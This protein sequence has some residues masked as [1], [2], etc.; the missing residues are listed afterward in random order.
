MEIQT[1]IKVETYLP[2]F[3]GFYES[4]FSPTEDME[5]D[6]I[7]EERENKG[8][9]KIEF[10]QFEF[11]YDSYETDVAHCCCSFIE[12]EL[13]QY[14]EGVNFQLINSPKE[15]NFATDSIHVEIELNEEKI[16]N[17]KKFI[18]EHS[19]EFAEYI[20]DRYTSYD[21]F[22]SYYSNNPLDWL[23]SIDD[24][25]KHKHQLGSIL[26]F[27][28]YQIM[29]DPIMSMYYSVEA[30]LNVKNY[31]EC[32]EMEYCQGCKKFVKPEDFMGSCCKECFEIGTKQFNYAVCSRCKTK[33]VSKWEE[34]QFL[35][36]LKHNIITPLEVVCSECALKN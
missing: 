19:N 5:I 28:S 12:S 1:K 31:T 29:K 27:I 16:E 18:F 21:G 34:R 2:I 6:Y 3:T 11:D 10:D 23:N 15:Y 22:M 14:V 30:Y 9:S 25:I 32:T 36:K 24:C 8:L 26:E 20:R 35:H 17:I 13:S 4:V 7:N 33:I